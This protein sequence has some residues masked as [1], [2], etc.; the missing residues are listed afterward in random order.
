MNRQLELWAD[1]PPN[2][3]AKSTATQKEHK[4]PN[5]ASSS[6]AVITSC[7]VQEL[8]TNPNRQFDLDELEV[9]RDP[10]LKHD[11]HSISVSRPRHDIDG[12]P[13]RFQV[14]LEDT[15]EV[16]VGEGL[17]DYGRVVDISPVRG[18]VSIA[19]DTDRESDW[20]DI[21][22]VYPTPPQNGVV[23]NFSHKCS[24]DSRQI[25]ETQAVQSSAIERVAAEA[26][27]TSIKVVSLFRTGTLEGRAT[28]ASTSDACQ[29]FAK[30]WEEN[31]GHDQERF[32]VA[33]LD[34]KH[35]IQSVVPVTVGTLDA[36]LV[37]PREVF[38]PAILEGSS[39][40]LLSHNHPSG[41]PTPSKEDHNVTRRLTE[42]GE[43]LGITVLDHI[44][45][46]DGTAKVISIRES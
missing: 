2:S 11:E 1:E 29:F 25:Y 43:L 28:I 32:V 19:F 18:K 44:V 35:R 20:F 9:D 42:A 14:R 34:T 17:F 30:Y 13:H 12:P 21:R 46:G 33:C 38:K 10:E 24:T 5:T 31:P 39:A 7:S 8:F 22:D 40:I 23:G 26:Q 45:H 37:H 16:F 27:Y 6:A 36:S 3:I 15:V 41:D 4:S